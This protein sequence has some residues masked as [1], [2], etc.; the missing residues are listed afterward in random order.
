VDGIELREQSH[1]EALLSTIGARPCGLIW[2]P[3]TSA[4]MDGR[5]WVRMPACMP[6]GRVC[7]CRQCPGQVV[8]GPVEE[9]RVFG[10][11]VTA[12]R[13]WAG[14]TC[15]EAEGGAGRQGEGAQVPRRRGQAQGLRSVPYPATHLLWIPV[16]CQAA[17][18]TVPAAQHSPSP[19]MEFQRHAC[20]VL[21]LAD[22]GADRARG[23]VA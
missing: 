6:S 10:L 22:G 14:G 1:E 11:W 23:R 4:C 9:S 21:V 18:G 3:C 13:A 2:L 7:G 20:M 12:C 5:C 15:R 19:A 8:C 17:F 16:R